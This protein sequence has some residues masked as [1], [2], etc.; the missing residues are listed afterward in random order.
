MSSKDMFRKE[1]R[2]SFR[3]FSFGLASAVIA[4]VIFGGAIA[5]TPVVHANTTT[6]TAAVATSERI[7]SIPYTVNIVDQAGKV[8][9]TKEKKV[10]VYTVETIATATEYLTADLVPEGYAIVSGLG[11]VTLTEKAENVFTVKVDKIAPE[12]VATTTTAESATSETSTAAATPEPASLAAT[13]S[14]PVTAEVAEAEVAPTTSEESAKPTERTVYLSYITHYVNEANETVDRT[15]H[16]VAVTTTDETAKTQVTVSASEN[17]PSGWELVQDKAKVVVQ[18]VENQTNILVFAVTK[19]SK[20]EEIAESQLSNRDVLMRLSLEADLLADEALRQVA[21]EQAGNTALETAAND[22]K[23][24]AAAAN[25]VLAN[26]AATE[27]ELDDQIDTVRTSTQN[28]AAEM[29]KV[30]KDGILTAMLDATTS[31]ITITTSEKGRV[32][33]NYPIHIR[34][35]ANPNQQNYNNQD[36]FFGLIGKALT[37][38]KSQISATAQASDASTPTIS[39]LGGGGEPING[40]QNFGLRD[41]GSGVLYGTTTISDAGNAFSWQFKASSGS[42]TAASKF[43]F[44]PYTVVKT[45]EEPVRKAVSAGV[46]A[47]EI[48]AKVKSDVTRGNDTSS[49]TEAT[50]GPLNIAFEQHFNENLTARATG[51]STT[52]AADAKTGKQIWHEIKEYVK[53]AEADG[54]AV[55]G[56]AVTGS[57]PTEAGTYNVTVLSTNVHGQTIE[58]TV[59]VVLNAAP[60]ITAS[61]TG[62][63][64]PF[65]TTNPERKIVYIF[66]ITTGDTEAV[67]TAKAETGEKAKAP[68]FDSTI[69]KPVATITDPDST[70]IKVNYGDG[71]LLSRLNN[72]GSKMVAT[73]ADGTV[74][75][76]TDGTF[77]NVTVTNG[78]ANIYLGGTYDDKPGG[79]YTRQF[80][81]SDESNAEVKGDPFYTVSYTD[82][83]VDD[84]PIAKNQ[85]VA[86]TDTEVFAKLTLDAQSGGF[87]D[88]NPN[89]TVPV[90]EVTRTI[91]GYRTA[92]GVY[93]EQTNLAQ[94]PKDKDFEVKVK[95]TNV[96]GQT[97]YNWVKVD[98]NLKPKVEIVDAVEGTTKTVYVFSK[99]NDRT[100]NSEGVTGTNVAFDRNK[101]TK[102]VVNITD[103]GQ[104]T[105]I[106]YNDAKN[107]TADMLDKGVTPTTLVGTDGYFKGSVAVPAGTNTT[108]LLKV[109]D[110][111]GLVGQSPTFR[112]YAFSDTVPAN[113]TPVRLAKG[114]S[115]ALEE[116]TAK[117]VIDSNSGYPRNP[118]VEIPKDAYTRTVVGYRLD[119][120][121]S[122]VAVDSVAGLPTEGSYQVRVK[123]SNAYGQE[124]Y[125][126]VPVSHYKLEEISRDTVNKYT[127]FPA[128]IHA[129]TELGSSGTVG[130][131]K[132]EGDLPED[133]NI[134]N[135]N[136]KEGE[137]A[138]LAERNLEFVKADSPGADGTVGTIRPKDGGKVEYTGSG[139]LDYVFEYTYQV[140]NENKTSNLTYTILYTDTQAPVMTPKSEYIRFVNE[141]YDI[142]VPGTDNAF[143]STEKINGTLSVLK[144]GESGRL[145][146]SDLG[147]NTAIT[148]ELDPKGVDVS[149][150]V[151]NQ[152]GNSTMFNVNITGTAPSAEGTGTYKL[153]VGENNYPAP[154]TVSNK[155]ENVRL[156]DIKVTFVKRAEMT[157]PVAVVDPA[158]LT[159]DEKAAVIAQL[160]KDNADNEKL[161][162]L[163]DTAFTVNA[164]GTVSVDYSAGNTGVDAVTDKVANATVKLADEQKKAKDAIDTKLA[165]EKAAIEAKRD[166]AIAEINNTPGLT[167]DQ[168]KAATDAVTNTAND[169]LTDLQTAADDA[170]KAIDT[171]TTVAGIN[172]AKT[173]GEK[174]LD[175][176]TATGEAAIEL[177]KEKELAKAD[178][179]N[180][181]KDAIE[182]IKNN[183]NLDATEQAPYIEAIEK[184]AEEQK[185][186]IDAAKDTVGITEA[187]D[188]AEKVNEEQQLAA[189]KEDAKDKI[190][191]E[192][193]AAKDAIDDNP[194]LSD[195]EKQ[196]AKDAVD[197]EVA[198][199]NDAIDKATTPETVQAAE[200]N[201]VKAIDA[202][203]LVA[204][205]Q[206]AKNKI[207]E[208][209]KAAKDAIDKDPNLSED[210][211]KGFKDAV[212]TEAAKAVADIEKATTPAEAQTAEEAGTAAIAEDVLDAAKQD[213]KNKIAK[214][215]EAANAA[216]ESNPNLSEDEKKGFKD[217]VDA[218]AAKA[219]ADI[220][221]ATTPEA[222][223]AAE[224]AGTKAIAEDV[225]DAAKQDAKNKI[226]KDL[227]T[228]EAAID[229]NSNLS[230][231]EK[232]AA[233]LEAQAKAAE[234]VANIEKATTP[235]AAQTLE[236]A[237]VKDLANIEIKAAYDDAV[238]AIEAADNLSTAAK[239]QALEDLKK[240]RQAAEEAIKTASTADEVAKGALDGLKSLA[241]VEAKAAADDAKAAIA[242]NSNLTDA[243]KKVYTDAIDNALKDTETKIDAATDADTVDAE[244][245][246]AQKDI[247]K[248]EVAAATADA[249]KG[250]E[251]NTN[252]TDAEKDEYKA[253]V[254]KAAE[255]AEKA[256]ADATTAA[257]IQSKT[258][259]ATQDVAKEEVKADAAD[260][261]AGI[262]ANDN[263]SDTAKEEAIA[264]IEEARDTT[265]ENI[266]N[267][268]TAADVDTA[269]LDAE[270]A[271]A[272][273]EI[274]AAADDAKKAIDENAN[275]PE[276]D[277]NALKLA[278]DAEVAATNL[279]IDNA[280]TAEEIDAATLAT[281]KSIAKAEVKAAAEDA[282]QAIDE[283]ANLTDD[284]K[285]KAKAD[286]YVELSKAEKAIDKA[287]TADAID[288]ATL[289]GEKAFAKEE[290]EAAAD[291]AKVAIDANDNLTDA[292]KQAA[293]EAVDAEVAKAN[294]AIDA[295]TKADEVDAATLAGEKA[296]AKEEV[297]A[298]ADD[299]KKAIDANDNLTDAEKQAAKEAVDAEVAKANEAID[300]ATKA[301]EVDAATLAGEKAV[302]KEEL[303]AAAEDAKKAID[304]NA[305]LTPEEKAAAKKAVD[306]EVAKAEKA[307]DAATKAEEVDAAT[308]A[309]EKAVAKE[310]VKAAAE[311]AKKAIDA[312]ANL[313]E[314]EKTALKLA[315][316]AEV[317]A[318]NLEIDNAK[319]AEEIDAATL[320]GEKAVAKEE[321]KAAAEDALRAIDENAN[322]TDDEKAAAKADV[323][324][325]LSKAEKAID[326]ATTADAIDNATL[327]GEKAFAKEEL[328]A[329]ADD[330][331]AAIDAND[332]LTPEEKAAAKAAVDAEVAKAE[333]AIDAATKADEVET[334]T[335]AG[336]KAVAKEE[337]K[338]AAADAKKAIDANDNLTPEEKAA[339]KVAVD[340]EVAKANDAIDAA[341]KA[342]EVDA[343]TLAG[344]KAVAKEELK[345]AADDAKAAIDANDNLTD[346][347]KQAAK[348]AV[349]AEVAKAN[350]AI[351]AATKADEV[352]AATLVGEKAVAKEEL[353]AAAEDAKKAID[354]NDN[355]T[356]AEKVAAKDAV[357][358][359]L[360]KAN[361]AIDAATKADEV[362]AATLAGEKAVAKEELKAA[363]EDAKK[364]IDANPNLSDAEKQAAKDAVDAELAKANDAIDAATKADEVDTATLAGEKAV[365]KE[366]LKAAAE[367]AKKAIDA[368]KNKLMEEADKAKAAIDANPNLT[369]EEKAAA[370]AE[371]DKAVEEAIISI[372]GAGTHHALGEIKLPLSALIKPVVTVTPVLDPNNLTEEEIARIKALLEENNTF[373]EGTEII[374]SKD[375]SVSIKYPDG[376]IDLILPAEIVKQADTTAPAIT[377]DAKGNIV[378]APTKEAVEFVVTYVDNNGKAQLVIVTKGADGKW[379][380]T[381]K[382]VIVDPVTGQ[383]IIPGSAIKPGT[384]VTAYS[385]DMAGN[386]S[387][388]NSA[389]VEAVDANNP[390]A[391]VKVKSV[392]STSNANKSTKKAKQLPNTGEKATSATS[393]GLAVLGMGLALFAAKRKKDEEEA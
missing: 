199:A 3:K 48:L 178:V 71:A 261:I 239:T 351:D 227:A 312:N 214:D 120:S 125:N 84:Q 233:K 123:T 352:D 33:P 245:V 344:E 95:T 253:T 251:A 201:G 60:T 52:V 41:N 30:D 252:L 254:T 181:A 51:T 211:K 153:R 377:D 45:D 32:R 360:A 42:N 118:K 223:Q 324:V 221:K 159:A 277:K 182:A 83:L 59:K 86:L 195:A 298:A 85:D 310:E 194:N 247:A 267:A 190:A 186:A 381:A 171:K 8:V 212:D 7:A 363:A 266:E 374:V 167:D 79:K 70:S 62:L 109:T 61:G 242:Q 55:S 128:P 53:V 99:N 219:V 284:E 288:N 14:T 271:N 100:E 81:I 4:N 104:V 315:I 63:T 225:L 354:A 355:L 106:V 387:D 88:T 350:E 274:K 234:A 96:Y 54:T 21:K 34:D 187:V 345:A 250:I 235:E 300:A 66:G 117:M 184:A 177:T 327:V 224:E 169:A 236:D 133:F 299:A 19:K 279:E 200:D 283:N 101:A 302:A 75:K 18:L 163:P 198:K 370:K 240:A 260:A 341:T 333:E 359:E 16:L 155:P 168:K 379:T 160:K 150:G 191:E 20:E 210:E 348:D 26:D 24:A 115:P 158:N 113:V 388:L 332:N 390:A 135:F 38:A 282:L 385:K 329:A 305:N 151:D 241:K 126:W 64:N 340:A 25:Q 131:V 378:V 237:A 13:Q 347:E 230:Q 321:V 174:A 203:E 89:L 97:I 87:S 296:V 303:K 111:K 50:A 36:F 142:S 138:K 255:T 152:G 77:T 157:T 386:V 314:S 68:I 295:A 256:I 31:A 156:T 330:A 393:L 72:L 281:E 342:D 308:L 232:D 147:T 392:T 246:L 357:D 268:K 338:A 244:T 65:N 47:D 2:F 175:D 189:A 361:D 243:E 215:V 6:E 316:D 369:P 222:A 285:A 311:D 353:K 313:P 320:V 202:E 336:E 205:K 248:Q 349:D 373:P 114:T 103:D 122:T 278:I 46:T 204:A 37:E 43:T 317:A 188:A 82:K 376:S 22:T 297:K 197:A 57:L 325:E 179:D 263:L 180:Q 375:A 339:A 275:L 49:T 149:G 249:V 130:T 28:L 362:D 170:K 367:D 286:V 318:T 259:D 269:T 273:A 292:E 143:L 93:T 272:K 328:E 294:D 78:T 290:L 382:A 208:D 74:L 293:K 231:D 76:A 39:I 337:L 5:N 10:L 192:A 346:A 102:A 107:D 264:A 132:L 40:I 140:N 183:P 228:V 129:I 80:I 58:N 384:V 389:E 17:M 372:N 121:S 291:D 226:A 11:E 322:L 304:E 307:I 56:T 44:V 23:A 90:S 335:L 145:V 218:E 220:E 207:A 12:A 391:G 366:A 301:D 380:T 136:L 29:L 371:I 331:K 127:D 306:D 319:T 1:Q 35:F 161:N 364:A 185:A 139:N 229:A 165:E 164:D 206:D 166:E 209:V 262:K 280:K 257:D 15:G 67:T 9:E 73:A 98:Y 119:S 213:A 270:K 356:D 287:T 238:K 309:G 193:A 162:A 144:D 265:L 176:A 134:A 326:K 110:D 334:A 124:I 216:I 108:R 343:A 112:V 217:A 137:A 289:V 383:V 69:A 141:K 154:P 358:A 365:A 323:Y 27:A 173:A 94:F 172:D 146:S 92:D 368:A 91:V 276:S 196:A 105:T 116:I 148:S 258:F